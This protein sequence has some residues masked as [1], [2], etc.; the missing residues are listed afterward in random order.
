MDPLLKLFLIFIIICLVVGSLF[1]LLYLIQ[2]S[3]R[4]NT[5]NNNNNNNN[6]NNGSPKYIPFASNSST[7]FGLQ[8]YATTTAYNKNNPLSPLCANAYDQGEDVATW[9]CLS[10]LGAGNIWTFVASSSNSNQGTLVNNQ[11]NKCA[12]IVNGAIILVE[13]NPKSPSQQ[14]SYNKTTSQI[15]N[16]TNNV[17]WSVDNIDINQFV[18]ASSCSPVEVINQWVI[19]PGPTTS[20]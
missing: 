5:P 14:W 11:T 18:Q 10:P 1:L 15:E 4:V 13:C 19:I 8:N 9:S 2:E 6:N 16:V 7:Q 3:N 12:A 17:C 20:S